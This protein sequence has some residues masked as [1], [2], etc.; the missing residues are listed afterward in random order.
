MLLRIAGSCYL[1]AVGYYHTL[2]VDCYYIRAAEEHCR[3]SAAAAKGV[4]VV[5]V[6]PWARRRRD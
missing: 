6:E 1:L 4:T 3:M 2:A 5:I